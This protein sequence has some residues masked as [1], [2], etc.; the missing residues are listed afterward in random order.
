MINDAKRDNRSSKNQEKEKENLFFIQNSHNLL[1]FIQ[2]SCNLSIFYSKFTQPFEKKCALYR[3]CTKLKVYYIKKLVTKK[4]CT[5]LKECT[6]SKC[7][8][9]REDCT[10]SMQIN[11]LC[12]IFMV[13]SSLFDYEYKQCGWL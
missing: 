8:K 1:F 6:K 5:K 4:V 3:K 7:T 13:T 9:S 10:T 2:N 12:L 11:V